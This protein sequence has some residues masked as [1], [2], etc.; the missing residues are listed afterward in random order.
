MVK[1]NWTWLK[2]PLN[3]DDIPLAASFKVAAEFRKN[4]HNPSDEFII[5]LGQISKCIHAM[6]CRVHE[7]PK[8][9]E[10]YPAFEKSFFVSFLPCGIGKTTTLIQTIKAVLANKYYSPVSAII[11]LSKLDEIKKLVKEFGIADDEFAVLTSDPELNRLGCSKPNEARIL[12]TTQQMLERRIN[13][14]DT[15]TFT[16]LTDFH[17]HNKPRQI[18]VW[19]EAIMPSRVMT[20][21]IR[22][23]MKTI[24]DLARIDGKLAS[25]VE[26]FI[27]SV[28]SRT[29]GELIE[30][31]SLSE[32]DVTVEQ[33]KDAMAHDEY[34][35]S[36]EALFA[37][38]GKNARIL[39]DNLYG[40]VSLQYAD[41]L[42]DDLA[43]MLI[44]DASGLNRKTYEYWGKERGGMK[45]LYSP[46]KSYSGLTIHHWDRGSGKQA[47]N[48]KAE[49]YKDIAK[50]IARTID[51]IHRDTATKDDRVLVVTRKPGP[52]VVDMEAAIKKELQTKTDNLAFTTWG[53]HTATNDFADCKHVILAGILQYSEASYEAYGLAAKKQPINEPLTKA[54]F[55]E[56]RTGEIASH[57]LQ[58]TCRGMVRKAVGN[59][60]PPG[61]HLYI[62]YSSDYVGEDKLMGMVFP[63]AQVTEWTPVRTLS[64]KK[65]RE[66]ADSIRELDKQQ[67]GTTILL[68]T[69][70]VK[71]K[72]AKTRDL[73]DIIVRSV[74][75]YLEAEHGLIVGIRDGAIHLER[76]KVL[77]PF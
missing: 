27:V 65:Q 56:T 44:L 74:G 5:G 71:C 72:I 57:I 13:E 62:I 54:E 16:E 15:R 31:P 75:P 47:L 53:Q 12:F 11:F 18:R 73:M 40:S 50:G 34:K 23:L 3:N 26:K 28:K 14:S 46:N 59:S 51:G 60:C 52:W 32:F 77:A 24:D 41:I 21:V 22:H 10:A 2:V 36:I 9:K 38:S 29:N 33:A 55:I 43:P 63:D 8:V 66:V 30:V 1:E 4:T 48:P 64:G 37:L 49:D 35:E 61:C 39:T 42:P 6:A 70:R 69:I 25:A 45:F 20:L 76:T 7:N 67:L 68:E 17:Y 19:D 58:A